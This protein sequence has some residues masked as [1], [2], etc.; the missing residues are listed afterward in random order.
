MAARRQLDEQRVQHGVLLGLSRSRLL[1][2]DAQ[3][4]RGA[5]DVQYQIRLQEQRVVRLARNM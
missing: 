3:G 4:D 2:D 1:Q 5:E